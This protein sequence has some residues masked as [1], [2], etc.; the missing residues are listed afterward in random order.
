M[1]CRANSPVCS[2]VTGKQK[3]TSVYLTTFNYTT[4]H[5]GVNFLP[6]GSMQKRS[7]LSRP[8]GF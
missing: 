2:A 6:S 7:Q 1:V 3:W 5:L 8:P 4:V